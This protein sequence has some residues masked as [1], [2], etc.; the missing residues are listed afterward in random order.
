MAVLIGELVNSSIM[1]DFNLMETENIRQC[2]SDWWNQKSAKPPNSIPCQYAGSSH[3]TA[4]S[5]GSNEIFDIFTGRCNMV[6]LYF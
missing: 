4:S 3:S 1:A 6:T 2:L 5:Y